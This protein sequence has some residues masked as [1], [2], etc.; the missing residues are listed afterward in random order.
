MKNLRD[1]FNSYKAEIVPAKGLTIS[2]DGVECYGLYGRIKKISLQ[3]KVIYKGIGGA[4]FVD[5]NHDLNYYICGHDWKDSDN[6]NISPGIFGYE[7]GEYTTSLR[8]GA[9]TVSGLANTNFLIEMKLQS[10]VKGWYTIWEVIEKFRKNH[11]NNWF[12]PSKDEL[13][14]IYEAKA[15]LDNL[16]LTTWPYYWC[17]SENSSDYAWSQSF[18]DGYQFCRYKDS[19]GIRSRL[20]VQY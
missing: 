9:I 4:I 11:S 17:S 19:H 6:Y 12:L 18:G 16:S 14:L 8:T 3:G 20:C 1:V 10:S 5:R 2:I 15:N 13:N 7:W